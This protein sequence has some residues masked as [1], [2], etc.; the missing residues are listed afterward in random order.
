MNLLLCFFKFF[1]SNDDGINSVGMLNFELYNVITVHMVRLVHLAHY[2]YHCK[3][4]K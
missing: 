3:C 4:P 2:C 1:L